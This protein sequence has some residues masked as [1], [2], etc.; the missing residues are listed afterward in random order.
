MKRKKTSVKK[1]SKPAAKAATKKRSA[2]KSKQSKTSAG[3]I[4]GQATPKRERGA[5]ARIPAESAPVAHKLMAKPEV[6]SWGSAAP[7][8]AEAPVSESEWIAD[9]LRQAGRPMHF[10]E[11]AVSLNTKTEAGK[12]RLF[13]ALE[14]CVQAGE[15]VRNRRDEYCL[16]ERLPLIVGTVSGHRD[17][18]GFLHQEDRTAAPVILPHRQMREVMH[19][20]RVAVRIGGQDSRGRAEGVIVKVLERGT[21]EI[22]GRL[23]DESGICYVIPDNPR[24]A[25]RVLVPREHLGDAKPGQIVLVRI[26]EPPSRTAQPLGHVV[27]VLGEH[28]APGMETDIAIHSHGLPFE[29]PVEAVRE[30]ESFG[31]AVNASSK[32]GREDLREMSLVTIDGEDSRDFDDAVWCEPVRGGWRLIVAIADVAS[33]V[34]SESALDAEA[35]HRGT[36]VYFPNRV[37]PMLPEALSNGLCSLNPG[38]DRLCLCCEMRVDAAGNVTRPRFFEGIMRSAARL[39]YTKVAAYLA[40]PAAMQD[41]QVSA[42]GPQIVHLNEVYRALHAARALRG[43]LDFDAPELKVKFG[44]DGRIAA[45]VEQSRND[46]HRL[47]EECMIAANVEA[48]RFLAKHKIP[49]LFRVHG[50]PEAERLETLR[51]FLGG[52]G[53]QLPAGPDIEPKQLSEVLKGITANEESRLIETVVVRSLPQAVYQPQNI[54]H[55]GLA[56]PEYAHFTSPIRRYPDLMVHRGIRHVI[57]GGTAADF[58]WSPA[59]MAELGQQCSFTERRADDATRDA[60]SWLKCEYM[61]DKIGEEFEAVV[62]SVVDF[63]LFVQLKGLQV[64]GLVHV[65]SLG[66]DYFSRDRSGFRMVGARSGRTFRLGD[67]VRV[68]LNSVSIDERKIDFELA[69]SKPQQRQQFG[70]APFQRRRRR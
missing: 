56:L 67:H 20:D 16:R 45:L 68:R 46:A 58:P 1:A 35:Q 19:G 18:H 69:E 59:R 5:P 50:Q 60:M 33:Y 9:V 51:Q 12:K 39:T 40:N 38:V 34:E 4:A 36:S 47:I 52:F 31:H 10:E 65:S 62:S 3:T 14:V 37:L 43:A 11:L 24:I 13:A 55:F 7:A 30:A 49:T 17:G 21:K 32:R 66:A 54:G 61:Q 42:V 25:H 23:Y 57:R 15:F 63:G 29:F 53:I 44:A 6:S 27:R 70:R 64:D 26:I 41:E 28:A 8:A 22:V 48:A 2:K